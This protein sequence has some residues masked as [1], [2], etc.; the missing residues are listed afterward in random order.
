MNPYDEERLRDEVI[1]LHYLWEQG[2]PQ[3]TNQTHQKRPRPSTQNPINRRKFAHS[4]SHP[5]PKPDPGLD[6]SV[7]LKPTSPSS[8]G[9]P[10]P[11]SKPD[12]MVRPVSIEDQARFANMQMQNKVLDCCKQFFKKRVRHEENDDGDDDDVDVDEEEEEKNE[13]DMFFMRIFVNNSELRGYYEENHEKGEFFCL[14]CGGIGENLG[15]KF[16][17]CVGLVQ[18]CMS[19][20]KTKCKTGHRAFGLVVCKVLGWDID[21]LPVILLRGEP[22]SRIL[23]NSSE[24]QNTLQGEGSNTNV[25]NLETGNSSGEVRK[26]A[27]DSLDKGD[28]LNVISGDVKLVNADGN[29]SVK[30]EVSSNDQSN[31]EWMTCNMSNNSLEEEDANENV[32]SLEISDGEP[33]KGSVN[34]LGLGLSQVTT[35]GWPCIESIDVSTSTTPKWPI[36]EPCTASI[37]HVISA[38]E[39]IRINMVQWQ[40]NVFD[41]CKQFLS[42]T[43][44]SDSDEDDNEFDEDDLMDEDGSNDS[45]EFN[46]FLSLFTEN[47]ELR[48]YYETHCRDGDF[49]CLVCRGIGKKD[50]RIFKDCVGLIQHSTAISKTKR[51][52]AHRAFGQVICKVLNWDVDH[53]PSIMSKNKP[54]SHSINHALTDKSKSESGSKED[55]DAHQN[56]SLLM[57]SE[58]TLNE[59]PDKDANLENRALNIGA[60]EDKPENPMNSSGENNTKSEADQ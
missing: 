32:E 30:K 4:G 7:L 14:V 48:S 53:L 10:E 45:N 16:Q 1:Y 31:G 54:Y 26:D 21:R 11:K 49:W 18:H 46:F 39:Q 41:A 22:L 33:N 51:K 52:Q 56:N 55:V 25:E 40:L 28:D 20:S 9:W 58:N 15:K 13:I 12:P 24:S 60:N 6:W 37:T 8:P 38:E 35:T 34:D 43:A 5:P 3:T 2:P 19:I 42:S 50:W 59:E 36:F 44:G 57:N 17:G 23:A 27:S 47:N 29:G